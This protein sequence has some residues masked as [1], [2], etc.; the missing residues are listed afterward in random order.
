MK[1]LRRLLF[2]FSVGVVVSGVLLL[3]SGEVT[4]PPMLLGAVLLGAVGL[5]SVTGYS[6]VKSW[7]MPPVEEKPNAKSSRP[8]K[9]PIEKAMEKMDEA[10]D[11]SSRTEK[12]VKIKI[13]SEDS[14]THDL[15]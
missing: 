6:E 11:F 15:F 12:K 1:A 8:P 2:G 13:D 7:Q 3:S 10:Q 9:S 5:A 14:S 4:F